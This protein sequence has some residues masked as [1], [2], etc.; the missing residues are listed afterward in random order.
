MEYF[1]D[2]FHEVAKA[3]H[4]DDAST[5]IHLRESLKD[6]AKE[7]GRSQT[8]QGI[9]ARLRGCFGMAPREARTKLATFKKQQ[10]TSMLQHADEIS[11]LV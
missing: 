2:Q 6:E 7:C 10:K 1:R 5:L 11:N 8:I 4:W 9:E 3:N